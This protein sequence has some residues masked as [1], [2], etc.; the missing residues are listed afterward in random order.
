MRF[1]VNSYTF[2]HVIRMSITNIVDFWLP[3]GVYRIFWGVFFLPY[4]QYSILQRKISIFNNAFNIFFPQFSLTCRISGY[5]FLILKLLFT[6]VFLI[7][8]TFLGWLTTTIHFCH[9]KANLKP[10]S[11]FLNFLNIFQGDIPCV[12]TEI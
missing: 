8:F 5:F 12:F 2:F 1:S 6:N 10:I 3:V 9:I 7:Y 4:L 11:I